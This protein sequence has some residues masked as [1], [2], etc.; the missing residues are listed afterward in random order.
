MKF[1]RSRK[2]G[3]THDSTQL[4]FHP[5]RALLPLSVVLHCAFASVPAAPSGQSARGLPHSKTLRVFRTP[6]FRAPEFWTAAALRR[7]S[8]ITWLPL[9]TVS[10]C[11][12]NGWQR[13]S[14]VKKARF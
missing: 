1:S 14:E 5:T 3:K 2:V 13:R 4:A 8:P 7:F 6:S 10:F 12:Q 11:P 9:P